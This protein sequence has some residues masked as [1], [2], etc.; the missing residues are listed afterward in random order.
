VPIQLGRKGM[1][2]IVEIAL[3]DDEREAFHAS[4]MAV[5]ELVEMIP[6]ATT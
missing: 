5:K 6:T 3:T 2:K 1:E 4:A